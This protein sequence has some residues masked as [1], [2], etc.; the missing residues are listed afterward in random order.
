[1]AEADTP[2][3]GM[4]RKPF[5]AFVQE[6]RNG[7]LHGELSDLLA[8]LVLATLE[9]GKKGSLTVKLEVTPNADGVTVT[10]TDTVAVKEPEKNR[11]AGIWFADEDG[12]LSRRNPYQ[13]ELPLREVSEGRK[14]ANE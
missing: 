8:E 11:G 9:H 2:D 5:A 10:I 6:H 3:E 1:M 4:Q 7:G 14:A 13:Q 12:N